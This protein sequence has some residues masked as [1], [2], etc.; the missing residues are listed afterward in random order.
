MIMN[1]YDV[2]C[3]ELPEC[4]TRVVVPGGEVAHEMEACIVDELKDLWKQGVRTV[5]SCCGHGDDRMAYIRVDAPSAPKMEALGYVQ[6]ELH[7]CLFHAGSVAFHPKYITAR[8]KNMITSETYK[9]WE[10]KYV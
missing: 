2:D 8:R 7:K 9:E 1:R 4:A 6:T 5:C 3:C 10:K